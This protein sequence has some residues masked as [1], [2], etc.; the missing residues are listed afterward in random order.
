MPLASHKPFWP[1]T[2]ILLG[3][4]ATAKLGV[5]TTEDMGRA[6]RKL[7][8]ED[9]SIKERI[10]EVSIFH[11]IEMELECFLTALGDSFDEDGIIFNNESIE[12][13]KKILPEN[14]SEEKVR[15]RILQWKAH[16]DWN[17]L[18]RLAEKVPI[19]N[20][21]YS[22]YLIDLYSIIDGNLLSNHGISD[23]KNDKPVFLYPHRLQAARNLL[24]LLSN[25]MMACAYHKKREDNPKDFEPYLGF[26]EILNEFM[27]SETV[28][29]KNLDFFRRQFYLTS[30]SIISFN[31]DPIFLW[32]RFMQNVK[33]NKNPP[34][35]GKRN[36]PVS[37]LRA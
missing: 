19:E 35:I 32:F 31:F 13:A 12:A 5:P 18:R 14:F 29:L 7:S 11:K 34:H 9:K 26:A 6:I 16:Y 3:A 17:A 1:E 23:T 28:N 36:L 37:L 8:E 10:D 27:Q 22:A 21:N 2:A 4:G 20:E 24:V 30:Y 25:L 33:S 15:A